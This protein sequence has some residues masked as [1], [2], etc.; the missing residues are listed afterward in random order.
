M[1]IS[2]YYYIIVAVAM[3]WGANCY[4]DQ[5]VTPIDVSGRT[6]N[7]VVNF[8]SGKLSWARQV[9]QQAKVFLQALEPYLLRLL[10]PRK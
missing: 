6:L 4:A 8:K 2:F 3:F 10:F 9:T 1:R 5:I 7:V